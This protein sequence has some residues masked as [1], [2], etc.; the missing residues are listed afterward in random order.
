MPMQNFSEFVKKY[1]N[2]DA[3]KDF[4]PPDLNILRGIV[5]LSS[6][7]GELSTLLRNSMF[8]GGGFN[9]DDLIDECGDVLHYLEVILSAI[10]ASLD[11]A[12]NYNIVKLSHRQAHGKDK[13]AEKAAQV[14]YGEMK[15]G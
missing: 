6:E 10:G 4:A 5:G 14:K 9:R 15:F 12:A 8:R 11:D 3:D 1:C 2:R 13:V 7:V